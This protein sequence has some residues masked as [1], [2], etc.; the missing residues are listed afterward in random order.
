MKKYRKIV[1]IGFLLY[2]AITIFFVGIGR[3]SILLWVKSIFLYSITVLIVPF[4]FSRLSEKY[5]KQLFISFVFPYSL[6]AVMFHIDKTI[7]INDYGLGIQAFQFFFF[8]LIAFVFAL[9]G[10]WLI[11]GLKSVKN[12]QDSEK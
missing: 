9:L 10:T 12:I 1:I 2:L 4:I 5:W 11:Q 6:W 7:F 3:N 8:W